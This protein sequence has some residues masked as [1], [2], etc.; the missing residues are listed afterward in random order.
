MPNAKCVKL[1]NSLKVAAN[2]IPKR[3]VTLVKLLD[4]KQDILTIGR[5]LVFAYFYIVLDD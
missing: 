3:S 1:C 5:Y 2:S 4:R